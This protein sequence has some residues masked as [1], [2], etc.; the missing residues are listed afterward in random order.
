MTKRILKNLNL[1]KLAA[2]VVSFCL[3][4]KPIGDT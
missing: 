3:L 1:V 4:V 2:L